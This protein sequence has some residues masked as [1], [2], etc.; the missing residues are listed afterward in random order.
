MAVDAGLSFGLHPLVLLLRRLA[1]QVRRHR[2]GVVAAAAFARVGFLHAAPD[3]V[4]QFGSVGF[5]LLRRVDR[6]QQVV[7]DVVGG[8]DLAPQHVGEGVRHVAVGAAGLHAGAVSGVDGLAVLGEVLRL[9]LVARDAELGVVG[10]VQRHL[11]AGRQCH[12][13]Q[14][15]TGQQRQQRQ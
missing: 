8:A 15:A 7:P 12:A 10:A 11:A 13:Q 2:G 6:A 14:R 9:H 1:L 5:E 3:L 4:R